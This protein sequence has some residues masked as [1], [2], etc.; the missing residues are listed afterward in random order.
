MENISELL[1]E[2]ASTLSDS[3]NSEVVV[4]RPIELGSTKI[5]PLSRVSIGFG[6]AG[7]EG[8][9]HFGH[10]QNRKEKPARGKGKGK[11]SGAG[12]GAKVRPVGVIVFTD[13]GV[14]VE[15]IPDRSGPLERI[16]EKIPEL[17]EMVHK[18]KS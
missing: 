6:G 2:M 5:I 17:I 18:R 10:C 16:F 7:G 12:G 9:Q 8:D 3:A 4:G 13:E 14:K 11:G 1:E 15:K